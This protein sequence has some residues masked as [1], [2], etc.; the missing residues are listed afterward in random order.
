MAQPYKF[1]ANN[2]EYLLNLK[3]RS[4]HTPPGRREQKTADDYSMRANTLID[5]NRVTIDPFPSCLFNMFM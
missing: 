3:D 1:G 5:T 4:L 2:L